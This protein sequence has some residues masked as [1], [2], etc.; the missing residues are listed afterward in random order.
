MANL[1]IVEYIGV[2]YNI[3]GLNILSVLLSKKHVFNLKL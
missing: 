1:N 3:I 2:L